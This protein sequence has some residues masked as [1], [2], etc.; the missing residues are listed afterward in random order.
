[1]DVS[2]RQVESATKVLVKCSDP[3]IVRD[4]D[5]LS[6]ERLDARLLMRNVILRKSNSEEWS[7]QGLDCELKFVVDLDFVLAVVLD[8]LIIRRK[9]I[10]NMLKKTISK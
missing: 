8:L 1:M 5:P 9:N 3:N 2:Y 4:L 7:P 6:S 10:S